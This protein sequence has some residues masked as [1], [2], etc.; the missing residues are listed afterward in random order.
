MTFSANGK[1]GEIFQ[2]TINIVATD[3]V[4]SPN[5]SSEDY[6]IT[7]RYPAAVTVIKWM[8][9]FNWL[10]KRY[11]GIL[12]TLVKCKSQNL[13]CPIRFDHFSIFISFQGFS[14]S[15]ENK[16][17]IWG[18]PFWAVSPRASQC[19]VSRVPGIVFPLNT[20]SL[21]ATPVSTTDQPSWELRVVIS[22]VR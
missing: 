14:S 5:S 17:V 22:R 13:S 21:L 3:F 15:E 7:I 10:Y 8:W 9:I 20:I 4:S 2:P 16:F 18:S 12:V 1:I 11:S 19:D 6:R